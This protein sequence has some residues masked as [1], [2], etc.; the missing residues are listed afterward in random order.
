MTNAGQSSSPGGFFDGS[1][2]N[3]T[4]S[5]TLFGIGA[6]LGLGIAGFGL[7]SAAGTS[8]R[9]VPPENV[10]MVNQRPILRSDFITQLENETGVAFDKNTR[11]DQLKVLDDMVREELLVQR[12]LELDFAETDQDAR[13]ALVSS[14]MQ[15]MVADVTTSRPS[16]EQLRAYFDQ[17]RSEFATEGTMIVHDLTFPVGAGSSAEAASKNAAAASEALRSKVPLEQV[18]TRYGAVEAKDYGEDFYF[19]AKI[20]LGDKLY[21]QALEFGD[22]TISEPL[23]GDDGAIHV[24]QMVKNVK[25]VPLSF[26]DAEAQVRTEYENAAQKRLTEATLQFLRTRSKILIAPDY[27]NDYKP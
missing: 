17:H 6:L 15:Q 9:V 4:R 12:A 3:F 10:A 8:T 2:V 11:E 14:V 7:F 22:G 20:H 27:A 5:M 24:L 18:K 26:E 21:A 25:P 23:V 16:T 19:A 13:N 1:R